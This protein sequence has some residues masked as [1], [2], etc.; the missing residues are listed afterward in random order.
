MASTQAK[1]IGQKED[2]YNRIVTAMK[3]I[4]AQLK[5]LKMEKGT[6]LVVSRDSK[7]QHIKPEDIKL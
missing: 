5:K 7:I 3:K 6:N 1:P 4:P 2:E